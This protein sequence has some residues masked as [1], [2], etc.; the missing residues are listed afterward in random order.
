MLIVGSI[1]AKIFKKNYG[2]ILSLNNS[3]V[4]NDVIIQIKLV[5][6]HVNYFI[7]QLTL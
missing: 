3:V 4:D 1:T 5:I 2:E 6:I 7:M